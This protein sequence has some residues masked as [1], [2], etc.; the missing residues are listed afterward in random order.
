MSGLRGNGS[1]STLPL[2]L[3]LPWPKSPPKYPDLYGKRRELA[4]IQILE[5]EIGF[6]EEELKAVE[7]LPPASRS[8]K[9]LADFVAANVD[10]L[11][12]TTKK[13]SKSH[14]L[15]KW[16][17]GFS[18]FSLSWIFCCCHHCTCDLEMPHCPECN[19]CRCRSK[20]A[21]CRIPKCQCFSCWN[22]RCFDNCTCRLPSCCCI[23]EFTSY[24]SWPSCFSYLSWPS[25]LTC[26]CSCVNPCS[27]PCSCPSIKFKCRYP[28]CP[29]VNV[30]SYCDKN[31]CYP[32]FFCF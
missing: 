9:E 19:T 21:S 30:C 24:L 28:K 1:V 5:R 13:I 16:L 10:P 32:C 11:I 2:P 6:L 17:C 23:P 18:C 27:I 14:R 3:P 26:S 12:P 25:C 20:C 15:W 4:K 29:K 8:C 22:S 31:C 7:G